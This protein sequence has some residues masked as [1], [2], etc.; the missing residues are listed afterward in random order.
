MTYGWQRIEGVFEIPEGEYVRDPCLV[1]A[2]VNDNQEEGQFSF[3][4]DLRIHPFRA[5]ME[6]YVY[7]PFKLRKMA[8]LDRYNYATFFE[9]DEEG[10]PVRVEKETANGRITIK[11]SRGILKKDLS[12]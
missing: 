8:Q 4:D 6:T 12:Q 11:E 10:N 7:H 1:I 3:F 9:Y 2:L 5:S